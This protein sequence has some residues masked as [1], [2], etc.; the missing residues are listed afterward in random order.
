MNVDIVATS[1]NDIP[2]SNKRILV[3]RN[4]LPV[5]TQFRLTTHIQDLEFWLRINLLTMSSKV[6]R[7]E[8]VMEILVSLECNR[9]RF[10]RFL[11]S[12]QR[13][14]T[15]NVAFAIIERH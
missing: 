9:E 7:F 14:R 5:V 13:I 6:K 4:R 12:E 11:S 3:N 2:L 10:L 8:P 1:R 15:L